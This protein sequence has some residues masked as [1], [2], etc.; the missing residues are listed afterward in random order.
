MEQSIHKMQSPA[1]EHSVQTVRWHRLHSRMHSLHTF[2]LQDSQ[3]P[4][5]EYQ[6]K[7]RTC[8]TRSTALFL[9]NVAERAIVE[10]AVRILIEK[11]CIRYK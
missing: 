11:R 4:S 10:G 6:L 2:F 5:C 7:R 8:G 1:F 9:T 3:T